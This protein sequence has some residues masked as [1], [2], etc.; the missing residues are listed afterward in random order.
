MDS[1]HEK[2]I[3]AYLD[4]ELSAAEAAE[5][6]STFT[7]AEKANLSAEMK[8]ERKLAEQLGRGVSC[9][10]DVWQRTLEAIEQKA[11][12]VEQFRPR[13]NWMYA[14]TAMAAMLAITVAGLFVRVNLVSPHPPTVLAIAKGTTIAML[15]E[16]AQLRSRDTDSVNAFLKEHGFNI[17]MTSA[18]VQVP[19]DHHTPRQLLGL[20]PAVNR[21][22]DVMEL[23][24]NCCGRP[25]KVVIAKTGTKTAREI[26]DLMAE[27]KLQAT[28]HVGDYVAALVG[29]HE[30]YGL[31]DYFTEVETRA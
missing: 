12:P 7:V 9:P 16:E 24:F 29:R 1:Q 22:E 27:G 14:V 13:R 10:N 23:L 26:G 21:G 5:F 4:G 18:D 15:E 2:M 3:S 11:A 30:T 17:A 6:D 28:R 8:F 20:R 19:G 25:L 31:L